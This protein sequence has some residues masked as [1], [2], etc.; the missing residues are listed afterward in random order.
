MIGTNRSLLNRNRKWEET[1]YIVYLFVGLLALM[2]AVLLLWLG[3]H[4]AV[5]NWL[6]G[7]EQ[8]PWQVLA[9]YE[10]WYGVIMAAAVLGGVL[11]IAVD[12]VILVRAQRLKAL[13]KATG[14]FTAARRRGS[15]A[16]LL[17]LFLVG[18]GALA[19]AMLVSEDIPGLRAM[20]QEDL[21][22]LDRGALESATLWLG[23][24]R[25]PAGLPDPLGENGPTPLTRYRGIGDGTDSQWDDFYVPNALGFDPAPEELYN[26]EQSIQWNEA[27]SA[28]FQVSY[29]TNFHLVVE[30]QA[31]GGAWGAQDG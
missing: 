9:G 1:V 25:Q 2:G 22:Q 23:A 11:L 26:Q 29:T 21:E 8:G 24:K 6:I 14:S 20:A 5:L 28:Q 17:V 27:N 12:I 7:E 3:M 16:G 13:Q 4:P 10:R 30:I 18:Y 15:L 19:G 31:F